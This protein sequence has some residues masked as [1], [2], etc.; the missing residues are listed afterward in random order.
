[1]NHASKVYGFHGFSRMNPEP[2]HWLLKIGVAVGGLL[3]A[4]EVGVHGVPK[5]MRQSA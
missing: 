1:M 4:G 2:R 3:L 5:F